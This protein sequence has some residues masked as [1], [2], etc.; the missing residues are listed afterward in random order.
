MYLQGVQLAV[1]GRVFRVVQRVLENRNIAHLFEFAR[2][3]QILF[4]RR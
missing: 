3:S 1:Q 4:D 2:A